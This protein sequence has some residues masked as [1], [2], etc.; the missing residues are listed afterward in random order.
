[1]NLSKR[2]AV[3][4]CFLASIGANAQPKF[5]GP[6]FSGIYDCTGNDSKEG[7]YKATATLTLVAAQSTGRYGAYTFKLE[8]PGYGTYPGHAAANG[9]DMAI[10]FALTDP[11]PR[12]YGT[13]IAKFRK[14]KAGK[15]G[16]HKFYYEPEFKGGN[17]GTEDCVRRP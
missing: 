6:D 1:M 16:F 13:G 5:T 14:T 15:W 7:P 11:A 3:A 10:H 4:L 8:V 2:V 9:T 12:D 17:H